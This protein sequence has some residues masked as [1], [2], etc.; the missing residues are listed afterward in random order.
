MTRPIASAVVLRVVTTAE[1]TVLRVVIL[2]SDG[3]DNVTLW[4]DLPTAQAG[5]AWI[6]PGLVRFRTSI[7]DGPVTP[8]DASW[9]HQSRTE[10]AALSDSL[11][12]RTRAPVTNHPRATTDP[13][14]TEPRD[15]SG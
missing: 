10:A 5:L 9:G 7:R 13:I 8:P 4:P 14:D 6:F 11:I 12:R 3:S 1:R 2:M 15:P